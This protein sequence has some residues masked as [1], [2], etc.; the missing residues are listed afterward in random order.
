MMY[1]EPMSGIAVVVQNTPPDTTDVISYPPSVINDGTAAA[2]QLY[3]NLKKTGIA[4]TFAAADKLHPFTAK[5]LSEFDRLFARELNAERKLLAG[6]QTDMAN[7]KLPY[8]VQRE[9][10]KEALSDLNVLNLVQTLT[11]FS[12]QA[13]VQVPYEEREL[14]AAITF[15]D[16]APEVAGVYPRI[17]HDG[18]MDAGVWSC[19]M[20][21]GLIATVVFVLP[22]PIRLTQL[23]IASTPRALIEAATDAG[24]AAAQRIGELVSV[25]VIPRPH[26]DLEEIFPIKMTG[27][28]E[29]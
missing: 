8:G 3:A 29:D 16:I 13:T 24:A 23:G 15:A 7:T 14:G 22:A 5:V 25:H 11:D 4:L 28:L 12:A 1:F 17:M 26:S 6:T 18:D 2:D 10:I 20:V 9:V 27:S 19:G 21:A